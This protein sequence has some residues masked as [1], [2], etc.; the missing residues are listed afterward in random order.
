M[1]GSGTDL[2]WVRKV[3]KSGKAMLKRK[4]E[5][6]PCSWYLWEQPA[7]EPT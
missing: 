7:Q 1:I 2:I 6:L 3:N 5:K 4:Y